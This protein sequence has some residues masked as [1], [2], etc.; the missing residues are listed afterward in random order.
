M[1]EDEMTDEQKERN[2]DE[3]RGHLLFLQ[4]IFYFLGS[5]V[6]V[7]VL[8][9][10]SIWGYSANKGSTILTVVAIVGYFIY[11]KRREKRRKD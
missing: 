11:F 1:A 5:V 10:G 7:R 6:C 4:I 2:R 9:T 3:L 8:T